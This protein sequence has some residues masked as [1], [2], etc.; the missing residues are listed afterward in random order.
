VIRIFFLLLLPFWLHAS[1]LYQTLSSNPARLNPLLATDT[2]SSKIS[3]YIFSGLLK[4]DENASVVGDLALDFERLDEKRVLFALRRGVKWHDGHPFGAW[5]V[6]FTFDFLHNPKVSTPFAHDFEAVEKI[7]IIDDH[8]LIVHYKKPYFKMLEIWMMGILPKHLLENDSSPLTS[9]FN[10]HPVGTGPYKMEKIELSKEIRLVANEAYYEGVPSIKELVFSIIPDPSTS[11]YLAQKGVLDLYGLDAMQL[12]K[13]V[14]PSFFETYQIVEESAKAYTYLGFNLAK[15][16]FQESDIREA[17]AAAIDK[18]EL[19]DILFF[20]HGTQCYGPFLPSTNAY[21]D[22]YAKPT[23]NPQKAKALLAKHG[24]STSNPLRFEIATNSA[25]PTRMAAAQILQNQLSRVGVEVSIRAVEWQAFLN[26][27][28]HPKAFDAILL[29]W[30]LSILPDAYALWHSDGM[31]SG[32]FNLVSFRDASVDALIEEA[33][34]VVDREKFGALYREIFAKIVEAN[35]YV[36]LYIP[37]DIVAVKRT[38][39]PIRPSIVGL[40]H[41]IIEWKKEE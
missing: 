1:T 33:Q 38:I 29:G 31:Q 4:Y 15:P 36:F 20:G 13:K 18:K 28:V 30:S 10:T 23:Y 6:A 27:V 3:G 19:V 41:N 24:Y 37:N 2:A 12:A 11:F 7:E 16:L 26:T 25:N 21:N 9:I 22:A 32:G 40:E 8:T 39:S 14:K 34:S 5:D 35:P 17:I